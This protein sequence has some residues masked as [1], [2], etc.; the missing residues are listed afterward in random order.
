MIEKVSE[1]QPIII[2][3]D[4]PNFVKTPFVDSLVSR[5]ML[6]VAAGLPI[7][8]VGLSGTG[9]TSLALYLAAKI[10][11]PV[12]IIHGDEELSTSDLLG[13]QFGYRRKKVVDNFIH[14]VRKTEENMATKWIDRCLTVACKYGYTLIYDEFTRSRPEA[15]NVLLSVLEERV[16]DL[17]GIRGEDNLQV[18]P[19][20]TAIF[21]SNPEEYAGVHALQDALKDRMITMRLHQYDRDTEIAIVQ[22]K[23]EIAWEEAG[24]IVDVVRA[25]RQKEGNGS[26]PTVRA[27]I[28][29]GKVLNQ[30]GSNTDANNE[31]F[32]QA[33]ADVLDRESGSNSS[34]GKGNVA[35]I[36]DSLVEK[37][38][39][40]KK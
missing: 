38:C 36:I 17:G 21:T 26:G 40:T 25:Y 27:S 12:L 5:A 31:I 19:D 3:R 23:A 37:H 20:F 6:Y 34:S 28:M 39:R 16:L 24:R 15:N 9:K 30:S 33:C 11:R 35:D 22:V 18:H 13:V 7:H 4:Q 8:L 2:T 1:V 29:I 14:S 32:K 10:G